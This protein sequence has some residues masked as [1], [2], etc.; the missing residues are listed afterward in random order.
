MFYLITPVSLGWIAGTALQLQQAQLWTLQ[1]Y[2]GLAAVFAA[3]LVLSWRVFFAQRS[4]ASMAGQACVGFAVAGALAF[5]LAGIRA[6]HYIDK[7]LNPSLEGQT[8]Q[9]VGLVANL[10][11]RMDDSVRFR[12]EVESARSKDGAAVELPPPIASRLVWQPPAGRA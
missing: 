1:V 9:V 5:A 8:L 3:I 10:P 2:V 11:Q 7:S 12:F 6:C 4:R